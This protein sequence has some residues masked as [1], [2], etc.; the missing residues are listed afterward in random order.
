MLVGAMF[1]VVVL[2]AAEV[3]VGKEGAGKGSVEYL[4][5]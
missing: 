5:P 3:R 1:V 4:K 2:V